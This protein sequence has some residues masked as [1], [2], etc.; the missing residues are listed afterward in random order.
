MFNDVHGCSLKVGRTSPFCFLHCH[1]HMLV[2]SSLEYEGYVERGS[3][4]KLCTFTFHIDKL[5]TVT[6]SM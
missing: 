5:Y 2:V 1:V 3:M 4:L 6:I